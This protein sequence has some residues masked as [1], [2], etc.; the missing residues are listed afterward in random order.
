MPLLPHV[1][2]RLIQQ[3]Q[4]RGDFDGLPGLGKPIPD[5]DAPHDEHWWVRRWVAREDL[6]PDRELRAEGGCP[7][8]AALLSQLDERPRRR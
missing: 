8:I 5:L 6:D 4:E 7:A 2:E 3:A 1:V